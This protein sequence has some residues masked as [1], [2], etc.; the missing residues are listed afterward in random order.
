MLCTKEASL[1]F[2]GCAVLRVLHPLFIQWVDQ[3]TVTHVP[4]PLTLLREVYMS[5]LIA[6][7]SPYFSRDEVC[8]PPFSKATLSNLYYLSCLRKRFQNTFKTMFYPAVLT[9]GLS[10]A[11]HRA[12]SCCQ[13]PPAA[14]PAL[15]LSTS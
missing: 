2:R 15:L 1:L 9:T 12:C 3:G 7:R 6:F 5:D 4:T 8:T 10:S 13:R 14:A 11:S